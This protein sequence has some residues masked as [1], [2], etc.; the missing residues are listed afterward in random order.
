MKI[1]FRFTGHAPQTSGSGHPYVQAT[2]EQ[3]RWRGFHASMVIVDSEQPTNLHP[4]FEGDAIYIEGDG[5]AIRKALQA[6][7]RTLDGI[8]YVCR[9][10]FERETEDIR[11]CATCGCWVEFNDLGQPVPHRNIH[12]PCDPDR[13]YPVCDSLW[14]SSD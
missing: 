9:K 10:R 12:G 8:E 2:T 13:G 6:G 14:V 1:V 11:Q 5:D 3:P 4:L 7:L